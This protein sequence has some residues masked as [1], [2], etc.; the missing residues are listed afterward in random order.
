M[1]GRFKEH[2]IVISKGPVIEISSKETGLMGIQA[3]PIRF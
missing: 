1:S 2:V 3:V